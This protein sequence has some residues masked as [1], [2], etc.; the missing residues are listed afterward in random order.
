MDEGNQG[1]FR[2]S[3]LLLVFPFFVILVLVGL[4]FYFQALKQREIEEQSQHLSAVAKLKVRA[5]QEWRHERRADARFLQFNPSFAALVSRFLADPSLGPELRRWLAPMQQNHRYHRLLLLDRH[6]E[7]RLVVGSQ[8]ESVEHHDSDLAEAASRRAVVLSDL[9]RD[10]EAGAI[11]ME[12]VVP[13]L[14]RG[15]TEGAADG[16]IGFVL[17]RV[18]TA[19]QLDPIIQTWPTVSRT[20]ESLLIRREGQEV[21]FLNELRHRKGTA[22]ALRRPLSSPSLPAASGARGRSGVVQGLDYRGAAVLAAVHPVPGSHWILIA[23]KDLAEIYQPV[24]QYTLVLSI[25]AAVVILAGAG[26]AA[27]HLRQQRT[28]FQ[29][30]RLKVEHERQALAKHYEYL[31][32][33]ANDIILWCDERFRIMEVNDRAVTSFGYSREELLNL[34]V[35]ELRAPETLK[36]LGSRMRQ[37]EELGAAVFETKYR[38]KDGSSFPAEAS[39]RLVQTDGGIYRHAIIRDISERVAARQA[40]QALEQKLR[41]LFE[42]DLIGIQIAD[43][44]GNIREANDKSLDIVGYGREDLNRGSLRWTEWT[45]PEFAPADQR[46]IAEARERGSC[47]PYEKQFIRKDGTRIWV[48]VGYVLAGEGSEDSIAFILDLTQHKRAEAELLETNRRL[49]EALA[50]LKFAEQQVVQQEQLRALGTMASGIAH[51]FNNDLTAILGFT[52]LL[53]QQPKR[54]ADPARV[55]TYLELI[56]TAAVD[57]S[58]VVN[59]MREFYRKREEGEDFAPVDLRRLI[60]DAVSLTRPKWASQAQVGGQAIEVQIA[61]QGVPPI[62]GNASE[63]REAVTNLILNAVDAMPHGGTLSV[64]TRAL[65]NRVLLEVSDSGTGMSEEVRRRCLEPFYSTKGELGTGLG[66]S[67]VYGIV[68]RHE[69]SLDIQSEPG[70]GSA[71]ALSFPALLEAPSGSSAAA[72]SAAAEADGSAGTDHLHVLVIDDDEMVRDVMRDLLEQDGHRV[73]LAGSGSDGIEAFRRSRPDLVIVDRAMPGLNGDQVAAA[74]KHITPK[75]PII[76]LTGF[77]SMMEAAGEKPEW[78]D[79][80]LGKPVTLSALQ[81]ALAKTL[82][83]T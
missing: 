25:F 12:L 43:S 63:L 28:R 78:V 81:E 82:V 11:H 64:S 73:V 71:F 55:R 33:Y 48:L 22:L 16:V 83:L 44:Q 68:Q 79:R 30:E 49:T 62:A 58:S 72:G 46:G 53:L 59:R 21:V 61:A 35:P 15:A 74:I 5:I 70:K 10:S 66:L 9:H 36:D 51:D 6:G 50:D 23:K 39:V 80:V 60:E 29:L 20:A 17:L 13:L 52:E 76:M 75:V 38:R 56:R 37:V 34:T 57:A 77:G 7:A 54:L 19:S 45:P 67:M 24:Q 69:A 65:G 4:F 27:L 18:D 40:M 14:D 42:S 1:G 41:A 32:K 8:D 31:S 3:L 2:G 47:T 26:A